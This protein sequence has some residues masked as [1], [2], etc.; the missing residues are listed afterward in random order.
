MTESGS[1]PEPKKSAWR[2]TLMQGVIGAVSL[3]GTTAI[4]LLVNRY[5]SPP[6]TPTSSPTLEATPAQVAPAQVAP[7]VSPVQTLADPGTSV[8]TSPQITP[9][10]TTPAAIAPAATAPIPV[11]PAQNEPVPPPP[12]EIVT[13]PPLEPL[14]SADSQPEIVP[15]QDEQETKKGKRRKKDKDD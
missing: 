10:Q 9:V 4:P 3:A 13:S 5:L 11:L 6:P 12:P 8:Q 7:A 1:S 14:Q 2:V 15:I